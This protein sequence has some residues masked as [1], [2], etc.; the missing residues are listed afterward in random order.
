[1]IPLKKQVNL[2]WEYNG[3]QDPTLESLDNIGASKLVKLLGEM[4][5]NTSSW[6]TTKQV[7]TYNL[8]VER[9]MVRQLR[10][11]SRF[12][13]GYLFLVCLLCMT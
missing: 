11:D 5:K 12:S 10:L 9:D 4:F 6:P 8:Q 7:R 1:V 13:F 3:A 2:E